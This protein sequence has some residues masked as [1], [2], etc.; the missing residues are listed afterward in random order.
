M[1]RSSH[2]SI[3]MSTVADLFCIPELEAKVWTTTCSLAFC[4]LSVEQVLGSSRIFYTKDMSKPAESALL[5]KGDRD[6]EASPT[7]HPGVRQEVRPFHGQNTL[8][9]SH[10]ECVEP[11]SQSNLE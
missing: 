8:Q 9:V 11:I 10:M 3:S 4:Q 1:A 7:E 5:E 6:L 2:L